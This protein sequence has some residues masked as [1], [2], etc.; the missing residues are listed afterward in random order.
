MYTSLELSK[1]LAKAGCELESEAMWVKYEL[2]KEAKLWVSDL[3]KVFKTTCLSG[4]REYEYPAYDILNDICVKYS[5]EFFERG[6]SYC[7]QNEESRHDLIEVTNRQ[8]ITT[9]ILY[10][11]QQNKTQEAEDYFWEHCKFNQR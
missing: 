9:N 2:W 11:L 5:K 8:L 3:N 10:L 7:Y 6:E 4:E 1:K